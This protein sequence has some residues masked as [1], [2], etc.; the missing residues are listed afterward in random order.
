MIVIAFFLTMFASNLQAT[1]TSTNNENE[2][3]KLFKKAIQEN[4]TKI[5]A[6]VTTTGVIA[7]QLF[8][9]GLT[10]EQ[11][12]AVNVL[13]KGIVLIVGCG[14]QTLPKL[15]E[16]AEALFDAPVYGLIG[17]L[18]YPITDSRLMIWGV[19]VQKYFV[20]GKTPWETMTLKDVRNNINLL[21]K[22]NP[23]IVALSAHD[24]CDVSIEEFRKAFGV[25][26]WDVKIGEAITVLIRSK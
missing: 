2:Q 10:P 16:R 5:S 3:F 7:N 25:K 1:E 4:P 14:H 6:G 26:Y 24:S 11:A 15:L 21:K 9:G 22:I 12:I 18:H 8:F 13:G 19:K 20:T 17:G 23:G